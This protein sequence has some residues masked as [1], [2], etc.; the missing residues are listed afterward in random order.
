MQHRLCLAAMKFFQGKVAIM[1]WIL[2]GVFF[3]IMICRP[4]CLEWQRS[5]V[6]VPCWV[7]SEHI[8]N[9][10]SIFTTINHES[11]Q[12]PT[13][14]N[15]FVEGVDTDGVPFLVGGNITVERSTCYVRKGN[16]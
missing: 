8:E 15:G 3:V 6:E 10:I 5:V 11:I 14:Q 12:R 16:Q 13:T 7:T 9:G 4:G 2:G 1:S